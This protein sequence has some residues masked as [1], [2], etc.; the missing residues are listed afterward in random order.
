M[1]KIKERIQRVI[2]NHQLTCEHTSKYFYILRGFAPLMN[3]IDIPVNH[4]DKALP[5]NEN[6]YILEE[7]ID[8]VRNED[9]EGFDVWTITFN[10]FEDK[11]LNAQNELV[12]LKNLT[13][14]V[15]FKNLNIFN[16][17]NALIG[18]CDSLDLDNTQRLNVLKTEGLLT[19]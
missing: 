19:L 10:F 17:N 5:L 6:R 2:N 14:P 3:N 15:R 8:Q 18:V 16:E 9:F 11:L 13:L 7:E 4:N 1:T 12:V